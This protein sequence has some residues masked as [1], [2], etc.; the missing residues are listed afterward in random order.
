MKFHKVSRKVLHLGRNNPRHQH[1]PG[2][3]LLE[4]SSVEK[5]LGV[6]VNSKV[7]MS[8]Q[9][10]RGD[11]K[12]SGILRCIRKSTASRSR[13]VILPLCSALVRHICSAVSSP[14]LLRTERHRAP[15][16]RPVEGNK[17]DQGTGASLL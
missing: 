4:N 8:Q 5:D 10:A 13:E 11:K 17:D 14:G 15:G 16:V 3:N 12:A 7:S 2:A 9:C 6:L 1:R